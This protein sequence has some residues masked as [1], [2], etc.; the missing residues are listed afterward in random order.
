[1]AYIGNKPP[2]VS[3]LITDLKIGEDDETKIDFADANTINFHANNSKEMVLVENALTPGTS[4]GIALGTGSLMWSDLFLASGGVINLNNGNVTMTHSADTLTVVGATVAF[5]A[6]TAVTVSNDLKLISDSAVLSLGAD[7]D[8]TLTHDGTTGLTIAANPFEV[9]SGG[10]ITL[11]AHTGIFIFQD[12][13]SEVLRITESGSGDV[14]IKL[15]TN[16]KDLIFTDNGDAEGFRI[17]DAAAGVNVAGAITAG[18]IIKTDDA[19]NATSTSDG[20]LQTD[21]G[22]SVT[23]DAIFGD[24]VS[25]LTDSAVLN[26]G[27]GNDVSITHD[28]TTGGT[29][30]GT[31]MVLESLGASALANNDYTGIVLTFLAHEEITIHDAVYIHT[32][33][34]E[35]GRADANALA[36]MPAIGVAMNGAD[37]YTGSNAGAATVKVL[38]HGIYNDS[39]GFG[40]NLTEGATMYLGEATG[41]VTATIPDADGDFVQI[42]GIACGPRDVFIN[43]S[44]NIIE[45]A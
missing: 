3:N 7:N 45:R 35:V 8:A 40:G 25:L 14:T 13:N 2:V 37:A 24:D 36:T 21:G 41:A 33:D 10:N 27:A 29:L 5:T 11:D 17:L 22:L 19:T 34:G 12:A 23:L 16:A 44:L 9:D 43:P 18:G 4:D 15:E 20:S 31:P 30:S 32:D 1:M 38:T 6:S 26:L 28:G 39:D 42:M